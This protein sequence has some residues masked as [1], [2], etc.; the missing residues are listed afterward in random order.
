[1]KFVDLAANLDEMEAANSR[2]ELVRILSEV[3]RG[4]SV[5]E[6]VRSDPHR[7][8][9]SG[10]LRPGSR[11]IEVQRFAGS[12]SHGSGNRRHLAAVGGTQR[13]RAANSE[14]ASAIC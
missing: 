4:C 10:R 3:Y 12:S 11:R 1:V 2:S 6:R 9:A 14:R 8:R 13:I 7:R 5:D